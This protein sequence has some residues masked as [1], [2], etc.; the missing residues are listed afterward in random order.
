MDLVLPITD[1]PFGFG[2][3]MKGINTPGKPSKAEALPPLVP[4]GAGYFISLLSWHSL[5]S[6]T[7]KKT[8]VPGTGNT[9]STD[10]ASDW[11][12][13]SATENFVDKNVY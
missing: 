5:G 10:G 7:I 3:T 4:Q 11:V 13:M 6:G 2:E 8:K 9:K 1:A 12:K